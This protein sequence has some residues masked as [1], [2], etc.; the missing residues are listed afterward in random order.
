LCG[1]IGSLAQKPLF[2]SES[3]NLANYNNC[4]NGGDYGDWIGT[5]GLLV[6]DP[7]GPDT[8]AAALTLSSPETKVLDAVGYNFGSTPPRPSHLRSGCF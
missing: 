6:P 5:D 3:T 8:Q 7:F 4:N 2:I 1:V